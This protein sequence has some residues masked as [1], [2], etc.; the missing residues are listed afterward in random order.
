M[1]IASGA[2]NV[3]V[4]ENHVHHNSGDAFQASHRAS[5][6]PH[7]VYIGRNVFHEDRENGVDLKNIHDVVVSQNVMYGYAR[8]RTSL[9]DAVVIGS[10]GVSPTKG[11]HR[12]WFLFN[13]IRDSRNGIRVEG[14]RDCWIIG[15]T[16]HDTTANGVQFDIDSDS[17]NVNVIN[18]TF[19]SIGLN[20]IGHSRKGV[21]DGPYR[22]AGNILTGIGDNYVSL[23]AGIAERTEITGNLFWASGES[24]S[25]RLGERTHS[26]KTAAE[27]NALANFSGNLVADPMLA[28]IAEDNYHL[29][30]GSPAI[31]A[32]TESPAYQAFT[33]AFGLNI[34]VDIAGTPRPVG[35]DWD[36]GAY[37]WQAKK[38]K[39]PLSPPA[40]P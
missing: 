22:V 36:I 3:W 24:I 20:G 14:A 27:I 23:N 32:G 37:E 11:P 34:R 28:N 6:S 21:G 39:K 17:R 29:Q 30:A 5:I 35:A 15:N 1:S 10:M 7:H 19:A 9:G 38:D 4:L 33:D 13:D 8:S 18:N 12:S 16:I 25:V 31:D 40:K 26:A 2:S